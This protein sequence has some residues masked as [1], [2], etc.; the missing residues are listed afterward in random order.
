MNATTGP[1]SPSTS[2]ACGRGEAGFARARMTVAEVRG[3]ATILLVDDRR[4]NL[5]A[6]EAVLEPLGHRLLPATSG[7][8]R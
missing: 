4:E 6:L 7:T 8:R 1:A 5:I 2:P 3:E